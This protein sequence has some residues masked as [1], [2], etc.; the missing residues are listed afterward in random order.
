MVAP[1][2]RRRCSARR[3]AATTRACRTSWPR[4][5]SSHRKLGWNDNRY[6]AQGRLAA[7]RSSNGDAP[8]FVLF[9]EDA[10]FVGR[11]KH[12]MLALGHGP[13]V[14]PA[15]ARARRA[16]TRRS[17]TGSSR[18]TSRSSTTRAA[19]TSSSAPGIASVNEWANALDV[20][21]KVISL[22]A[23]PD[24]GRA[25]PEHAALLLRGARHRRVPGARLRPADRVPRPDPQGHGAAPPRLGGA[26]RRRARQEGRF[27]QI[28]GEI[29]EIKPGPLGLRVHVIEQARARTRAG[30]TSPAS[31]PAPASTSRRSRVPL[32]RRLVEFYQVP[33]ED[34]RHQAAVEL[35]RPRPRPARLAA[36]A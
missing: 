9:D 25:G 34:G 11:A 2:P 5:T 28:I 36:A 1:E 30:S 3:A 4:R 19:A 26:D 20:G 12:V 31:S 14:V 18:R 21:A 22:R 8:H 24:A 6:P 16:R 29:D 33:I 23:Q 7:A 27:E 13:L 32:L 10:N 35:R 15:G 17:P